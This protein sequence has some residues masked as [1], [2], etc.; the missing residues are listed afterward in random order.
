MADHPNDAKLKLQLL[1]ETKISKIWQIHS[2]VR[3][4]EYFNILEYDGTTEWKK[5]AIKKL[6]EISNIVRLP[7]GSSYLTT[8]KYLTGLPNR[9]SMQDFISDYFKLVYRSKENNNAPKLKILWNEL[10]PDHLIGWPKTVPVTNL[11]KLEVA[12][13]KK[14]LINLGE[15]N[16]QEEFFKKVK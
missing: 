6:A 7:E 3:S 9:N 1:Q 10:S 15:I 12:D 11:R 5:T 2:K 13:L 8:T 16:F 4:V 14:I